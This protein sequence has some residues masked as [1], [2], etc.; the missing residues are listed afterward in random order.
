MM[1]LRN[2]CFQL[3][4]R[5]LVMGETTTGIYMHDVVRDYCRQ[6]SSPE[7]LC[8]MQHV[9]VRRLLDSRLVLSMMRAAQ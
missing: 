6:L 7:Q 1:R 8:A 5:N 9:F 3:L 4:D 2:L